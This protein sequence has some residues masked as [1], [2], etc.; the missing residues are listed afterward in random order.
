MNLET[1][2][3]I[4]VE[5][6]LDAAVVQSLLTQL[7]VRA[8]LSIYGQ[9]GKRY[10]LD[11][12]KVYNYAAMNVP[13][14]PWLI[15]VDKDTQHQCTP[16]MVREWLPNPASSLCFRV[17]EPEIEAWLMAD[18]HNFAKFLRVSAAR[19]P[20]FPDQLQNA[21]EALLRIA[22]QSRSRDIRGDMCRVT[23]HGE[24]VTGPA[25]VSRLIEF[26]KNH[27]SVESARGQSP[28][29]DRS[30]RRILELLARFSGAPP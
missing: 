30:I 17:V 27:W 5:G 1:R 9:R 29:L 22:S 8:E 6:T 16:S 19:I 25:Y 15:L 7:G 18:T 12:L 21:K 26:A 2:I 11:R 10:I 3:H 14:E 24:V 13:E 20:Q 4:V 23:R 28:C